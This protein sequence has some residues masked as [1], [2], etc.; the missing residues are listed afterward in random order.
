MATRAVAL[1]IAGNIGRDHR[2]RHERMAV[3]G[4]NQY[5][6]FGDVRGLAAYDGGAGAEF[7]GEFARQPIVAAAITRF[8]LAQEDRHPHL[9]LVRQ[10]ADVLPVELDRAAIGVGLRGR[11]GDVR[12]FIR[13]GAREAQRLVGVTRHVRGR[14]VLLS[15]RGRDRGEQGADDADD[16]GDAL[17]RI[18]A[19]RG[20]LLERGDLVRDFLGGFLGFVRELLDLG[21]DDGKAAAGVPGARRFDGRVEGQE[22]GLP[23]HGRDQAHHLADLRRRL[24]Q[25][26]DAASG[27]GC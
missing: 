1:P 25:P 20:V 2:A 26:V 6:A 17:H 22:V 11:G 19:S 23:G 27:A 13:H 16:A 14:I 9:E 7:D 18:E 12:G 5:A 21:G 24:F 15:D 3:A 4:T 8:A 10:R